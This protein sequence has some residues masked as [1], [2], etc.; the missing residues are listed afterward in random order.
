MSEKL[1]E[2]M[3]QVLSEL[4]NSGKIKMLVNEAIAK[5]ISLTEII[6]KGLRRDW[7]K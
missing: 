3:R 2:E 4:Q 5:K 1:L 6:E 7:K